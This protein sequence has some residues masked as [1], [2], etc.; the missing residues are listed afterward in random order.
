MDRTVSI[1]R[2]T[3][4]SPGSNALVIPATTITPQWEDTGLSPHSNFQNATTCRWTTRLMRARCKAILMK[5][6]LRRGGSES[7]LIS[8][9]LVMP[10]KFGR[11]TVAQ[12]S[13]SHA[14]PLKQATRLALSAYTK[15]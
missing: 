14:K 1:I 15:D 10:P 3:T 4:V 11:K 6:E 8:D 7:R 9:Q 13:K 12:R 2:F 5:L